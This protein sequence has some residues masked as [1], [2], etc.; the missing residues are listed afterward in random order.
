[1]TSPDESIV[2]PPPPGGKVDILIVAGEHSGDEHAAAVAESLLRRSPELSIAA[3]GGGRLQSAGAQL[4][5]DLTA[6]SV[7]GLVEV[8]K[9]YRYFK[10]LFDALLDW[11][12]AHQPRV[13][14][15]V[16]YPGFNLRLA[17]AM[18]TRGLSQKG[19]GAT[20]VYAYISPQIWAWKARRRFRMAEVLDEVGVIFPFEVECY[21]DTSL[22]ARFVGHPFLAPGRE[23]P[24]HYDAAGPVLLLPGSRL[25]PI[26]RILPPMLR[27]AAAAG[28]AGYLK[29]V[30]IIYPGP[31]SRRLIEQIYA[32]HARLPG[33]PRLELAKTGEARAG[34]A[35]LTSSGTMSLACALGGLPGAIVYRAHP[36]TYAIGR[37]IVGIPYLGIANLILDRV[38]YPEYIQGDAQPAKLAEE[39][40]ACL[41]DPD[42]IAAAADGAAELRRALSAPPKEDAAQ[43][44]FHWLR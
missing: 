8:L 35:V 5:H 38:F 43:R 11:I 13:V 36:L 12:E 29:E 24:L 14:V 21:A 15:L 10:R 37:R 31:E 28:E 4:L 9:H 1:M 25:Q 32:A 41:Q 22:E 17:A 23:L 40:R 39:L 26:S 30:T 19:G 16:D 2:L 3:I 6:T 44:I 42:R 33:L 7:V 20:A 34:S 18:K 27:A